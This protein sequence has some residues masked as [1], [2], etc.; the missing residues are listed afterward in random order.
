MSL[1]DSD[2]EGCRAKDKLV[3]K[4]LTQYTE[5][6]TEVILLG[7]AVGADGDFELE[8]L[9]PE[10]FIIDI[11]KEV[12]SRQLAA[13]DVDEITLQGEGMIW[14]RIERFLEKNGINPN[15]G[16][17]AKQLRK[18]LNDMN[19]SSDLPEETKQKAIKL[20]QTIRDAFGEE[21][22]KSS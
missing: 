3:T 1:F 8:D 11:V 14:D 5:S 7:D 2:Q 20:F 19:S 4:W 10:N 9:F 13:A 21:L 15:K 17:I 18:K 16:S 22:S 12:H 6:H